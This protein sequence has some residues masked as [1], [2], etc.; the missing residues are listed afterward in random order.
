VTDLWAVGDGGT[1]LH[2]SDGTTWNA[3]TSGTTND[4]TS[5]AAVAANDVFAVG[6]KGTILHYDGTAWTPQR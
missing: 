2:S 4:L 3:Q 1:I 5:V 6:D